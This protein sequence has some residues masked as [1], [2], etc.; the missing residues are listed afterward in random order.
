MEKK[1]VFTFIV[2][3]LLFISQKSIAQTPTTTQNFILESSVKVAGLTSEGSLIGLPVSS[4]NR[5]VNYFDGLG[6]LMQS[7]VWKGS[8][9][10]YDLVSVATYDDLG[11]PNLHYLPFCA[12]TNDAGFKIGAEA[13]ALAYYSTPPTGVV[14]TS[15]PYSK[16]VY[17]PSPM[18]RIMEQGACGAS[19][20]P[21]N[22][23][24]TGSGH[25]QKVDYKLNSTA[26]TVKLWKITGTTV[27]T[28]ASYGAGE[29]MKTLSKDENWISGNAGVIE[30]YKDMEGKI[31]CKR[32]WESAVVARSTHYVYDEYNRLRYVIPPKVTALSLTEGSTLEFDQLVYAYHYD[33]LGRI[34]EKKIPGKGWEE[35]VYDKLDRL[36]MSRDAIQAVAGK[37]LFSKYDTFSRPIITGVISSSST[38]V[39]WQASFN[40]TTKNC[41]LRDNTNVSGTGTGYTNVALP[42]HNLV[43][44]YYTLNY[45]DDYSFYGNTFGSPTGTQS[46]A[47]KSLLTG[48]KVNIL[49]TATM[50]LTANYYDAKGRLAQSRAQN[51]LSGV[52][53]IDLVYNF[54]DQVI[55][56]TRTHAIGS[57]STMIYLTYEY[58]HMGRK[59]K[60]Y[61]KIGNASSAQV[62]LSEL[63]Y[64][65]IGQLAAKKRNNGLNTNTFSYNERGWLTGS[66]APGFLLAFNYTDGTYPQYNGNIANQQW[67]TAGGPSKTYIYAYDKLNRLISGVST[68]GKNEQGIS[69]D[70][71]GNIMTLTRD[72]LSPQVYA[73]T[74]NKL[75]VITGGLTRSY[76]YDLNGN[77]LTDGINTFTYNV[78]NLPATI[79]GANAT[80]YTYDATGKKL[81]R[82]KGSVTTHYVNGI[83]YTGSSID[84]IQTE[85]GIARPVSGAYTY[86][87]T[88]KDHLGNARYS[89]NSAGTKIQSDDYY[90]FG[91]AF[92]SYVLG[93]RN[94]YLYNGKELQ[95]GLEQYDYRARFYDPAV[96][97]WNT[98]DP[99]AE[100][101]RRFS[102]YNH[103]FNNPLRFVDPDGMEPW[104]VILKG[105][106]KD[107]AL[108]ELKKAVQGQLTLSMNKETGKV[109]YTK[110]DG[111][112]LD[113]NSSQLMTAIDDHSVTVN[114][115]AS[116]NQTES[117]GGLLIGGSLMG[118]TITDKT[119]MQDGNSLSVVE[120]LQEVNVK[121]LANMSEFMGKPGADMLHEVTE[122][123]IAGK[124]SQV[125][126]KPYGFTEK[127]YKAAHNAAAPQTVVPKY[128]LMDSTGNA[129]EDRSNYNYIDVYIKN[130]LKEKILRQIIKQ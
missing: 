2:P 97:R 33:G 90:P 109:S 14:Q 70:P 59:I 104:D 80:T 29:L 49:G 123:Y 15:Y 84:F 13:S 9:D 106:E 20:Q 93:A 56:N 127:E 86:E 25:T 21:L 129:T 16:A 128:R 10:Q 28:V 79:T 102:T 98:I 42:A 62:L 55:S 8:N 85:E 124:N 117:Q 72:A 30:E 47:V 99:L 121:D 57:T 92:N 108:E 96:G 26:D 45:Y 95:D 105:S 37:W 65:G 101:M 110:V 122:S 94:N 17:E 82:V 43:S 87:Y 22:G 32:V 11:R 34:I 52:D 113:G 107:K 63:V 66:A 41:E 40:A 118:N 74:G 5:S 111:A 83:Q 67:S 78:L 71:M 89:F 112:K 39:A 31:V 23:S 103:A 81:T 53:A 35:M 6:R 60:T 38:R 48:S 64:N 3:V 50:L 73:Y 126:G 36:V 119:V 100:K 76:T 125:S 116:N 27:S 7:V 69:Y 88:L 61:E 91:K 24:V 1:Y 115:E 58:D 46:T 18:N 51:H 120:T 130:G 68:D 54:Q 12:T 44:S 114:V 75:N 4:V 77:A 19:W